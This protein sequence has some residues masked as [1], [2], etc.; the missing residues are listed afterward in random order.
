MQPGGHQPGEVR[1]VDHQQ[2]AD[3]VRDLPEALEVQEPRVGRP[4]GE[5]HLRAALLGDPL[6]RVHVD[7]A[8]LAVDL[9]GRDVVQP[10]RD[11]DLHPVR[12][13]AAVG[14]REAHQRVAGL[15]QRVVDGGVGL[16]AGVR[17]DVRVLGAEQG[18]RAVDR[19][20][21][22]DVDVLAAAVVA[23]AGIALGVLVRQHG[24]LALEDRLRHEVLG[25]DHLQRVLLPAQLALDRL[26]DLGVDV[27]ER[28]LEVVGR[29]VAH[30]SERITASGTAPGRTISSSPV[31]S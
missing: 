10:A 11:V 23:L 1:H 15:E 21:L 30:A 16:R 29:E 25:G 26:G 9:V 20:L 22:D 17:L 4:A 3:L 24:A 14:Q 7:P 8:R 2:R 12:E 31:A 19:Q 13:V 6:D 5:D 18:L 27:G 28:A